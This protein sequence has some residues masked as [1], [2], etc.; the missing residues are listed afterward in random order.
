MVDVVVPIT[1]HPNR[2]DNVRVFSTP[3]ISEF[4]VEWDALPGFD[5]YDVYRAYRQNGQYEKINTDPISGTYFEDNIKRIPQEVNIAELLYRTE[6]LDSEKWLLT[7]DEIKG[8]LWFLFDIDSLSKFVDTGWQVSDSYGSLSTVYLESQFYYKSNFTCEVDLDLTLPPRSPRFSSSAQI[9]ISNG[10]DANFQA[11]IEYI[12]DKRKFIIRSDVFGQTSYHEQDI[13]DGLSATIKIT[14]SLSQISAELLLDNSTYSAPPVNF[15]TSSVKVFLAGISGDSPFEVTFK[16]LTSTGDLYILNAPI[17]ERRFEVSLPHAPVAPPYGNNDYTSNPNFV[18]LDYYGYEYKPFKLNGAEGK[19]ELQLDLDYDQL[20]EVFVYPVFPSPTEE[21]LARYFTYST[22]P[23]NMPDG[24]PFYKVVPISDSGTYGSP[25]D[26]ATQVTVEM[27][28]LNWI[29]LEATRR[30][31]WLLDQAGEDVILLQKKIGGEICD[32]LDEVTSGGGEPSSTCTK[33]FSTG[34]LGG[35]EFPAMLRVAPI[36]NP[37]TVV[38]KSSGFKLQHDLETWTSYTP[39]LRQYDIIRRKDGMMYLLGPVTVVGA[40][41]MLAQQHFSL[42][43]LSRSD[44]RY[45]YPIDP[46]AMKPFVSDKVSFP[47][48]REWRGIDSITWTNI[49]Y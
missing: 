33:C 18:T 16:S 5:L 34:Y 11:E 9:T 14:R 36:V 15:T 40:S 7:Q 37:K 45:K 49:T 38:A 46:E 26:T 48:V 29:W 8:H 21:L 35:Y 44:I 6:I 13:E 24:S 43:S 20:R 30:N 31:S 3:A 1:A 23:P 47:D 22:E 41:G 10:K 25:I 42:T 12:N 32:C 28:K 39:K 4:K 17:A 19:L 2:V 27:E